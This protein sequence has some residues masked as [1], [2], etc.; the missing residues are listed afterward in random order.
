M[1]SEEARLLIVFQLRVGRSIPEIVSIF[2][3]P[4]RKSTIYSV[5]KE[6]AAGVEE[7]SKRK[8]KHP[9]KIDSKTTATIIRRLLT[10]SP[11]ILPMS[12]LKPSKYR[13]RPPGS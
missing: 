8:Q 5:A 13:Q 7:K 4:S 11:P 1:L 9:W 6:F 12:S 3:T 10:L 2:K